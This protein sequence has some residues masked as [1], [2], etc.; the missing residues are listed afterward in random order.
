LAVVALIGF[1]SNTMTVRRFWLLFHLAV[2]IVI[3]SSHQDSYNKN[4]SSALEQ[5]QSLKAPE[6]KLSYS[7]ES[8]NNEWWD[9][10]QVQLQVARTEWGRRHHELYEF[11]DSFAL[12]FIDPDLLR[13]IA[14]R[15]QRLLSSLLQQTSVP[16]VFTF[17]LLTPEFAQL[18]LDELDYH[19]ES[20]IPLRRPNGMNRYGSILSDLGFDSML[21]G[22]VT[23]Y[24]TP[25]ARHLFTTHVGP[26]DITHNYS[27]VVR[28][29]PGQDV[30]LSEHRDAS[31]VTV[32]ICLQPSLQ[33]QVL[34]FRD[35]V[36]SELGQ[37]QER[38]VKLDEPGRA[39]IHLGQHTHGVAP[40]DSPRSNL[41]VW[42]FGK[43]GYVRIVPYTRKEV[44]QH[45]QEYDTF[46]KNEL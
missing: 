18:L 38:F 43:D 8:E 15:D 41:V 45:Q 25:I 4:I 46:W 35:N 33:E 14:T 30:S 6:P 20:G 37:P 26:N 36:E 28:Y 9:E 23:H 31:A 1:G 19:E 10:H 39:V 16:G 11:N 32:N 7:G 42:M 3:V 2:V 44:E 22:F 29:Q 34:Y 40:V 24:L 21:Q 5:A 12:R 13:A 27:F 17:R